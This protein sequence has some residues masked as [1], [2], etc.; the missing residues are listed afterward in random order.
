MEKV[1]NKINHKILINKFYFQD[2]IFIM[3][4]GNTLVILKKIKKMAKV[5]MFTLMVNSMKEC[6]KWEST[7]FII[8]KY[9]IDYIIIYRPEGVG[10]YLD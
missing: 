10:R 9:Y 6:S 2:N 1:H 7:I 3:M 5:Y 8:F 4:E